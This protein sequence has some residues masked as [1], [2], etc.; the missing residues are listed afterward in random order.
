[1]GRWEAIWE[2]AVQQLHFCDM[3]TMLMVLCFNSPDHAA[4]GVV[5]DR[6]E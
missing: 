4:F 2:E 1:M 6:L 5:Y 3:M